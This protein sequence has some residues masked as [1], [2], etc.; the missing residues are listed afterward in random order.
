MST[1]K[2]GEELN[3]FPPFLQFRE[4]KKVTS[5][6]RERLKKKY[7]PPICGQSSSKHPSNDAKG[8]NELSAD[9]VVGQ[10]LYFK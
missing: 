7:H 2:V 1:G 5:I 9:H 10:L 6:R 3:F 4:T 8:N